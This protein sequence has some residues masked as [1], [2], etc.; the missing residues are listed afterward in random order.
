LRTFRGA[1]DPI[2]DR[3]VLG[4]EHRQRLVDLEPHEFDMLQA[5]IGL[6]RQYDPRAARKFGK[7][8]GRLRQRALE[9]PA[10][11]GRANLTV[12]PR[13]ILAA[14]VAEFEKRIDEEPE[15]MLGRKAS[16]ARMGRIDQPQLLQVLHHIADGGG[17]QR[18][19]EHPREMARSD[20]LSGREVGFDDAPEYF[21]RTRVEMRQGAGF[22][23]ID[24]SGHRRT[25]AG[26]GS[27]RK[28]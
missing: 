28:A 12:D 6:C 19:R 13:A 10:F 8:T 14:K 17:G 3:A 26:R 23:A 11:R 24:G 25:M 2:L 1:D 5:R 18:Y 20:R 16:C 9:A 15:P 27:R 21:A 4:D 7:D 22:G